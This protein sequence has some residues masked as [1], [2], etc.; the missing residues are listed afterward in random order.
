MLS[1]DQKP[2]I[3]K[4]SG[5]CSYPGR[6][7][8]DCIQALYILIILSNSVPKVEKTFLLNNQT[9]MR[10]RFKRKARM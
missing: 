8:E 6:T 3:D 7:L 10:P 2:D 5:A 4:C 1:S 9:L